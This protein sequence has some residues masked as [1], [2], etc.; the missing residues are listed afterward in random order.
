MGDRH[1]ALPPSWQGCKS[2]PSPTACQLH[3]LACPQTSRR[4]LISESRHTS[5]LHCDCLLFSCCSSSQHLSWCLYGA[6]GSVEVP[7]PACLPCGSLTMHLAVFLGVHAE[8]Q[9]MCSHCTQWLGE[10]R[11]LHHTSR[12]SPLSHLTG[13]S[14]T[15]PAP[16]HLLMT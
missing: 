6:C 2:I 15:L 12:F 8:R 10:C 4:H 16:P 14:S 7:P 5:F 3:G 1:T 13:S 11:L 9:H